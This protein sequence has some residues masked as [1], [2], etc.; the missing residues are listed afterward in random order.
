MG[1]RFWTNDWLLQLAVAGGYALLYLAIHPF[2]TAHWPIH[3][4]VRMACLLLIPYRFWPALLI[5]EALPNEYQVIPCLASLGP[6]WVAVRSV[7]PIAV[8]MLI[9]W[10]CRTWMP[11]FPSKKLIDIKALLVCGL[12]VSLG[13][14]VYSST[15]LAVATAPTI[16]FV[17]MNAVEYF[18]GPYLGIFSIV[19]W[20]LM[21]KLDYKPGHLHEQI[22][23]ALSSRLFLD[24]VALLIPALVLLEW[25]SYVGNDQVKQIA[26]VA[27]FLPMAWLTLKHGWRAAAV[28]GPLAI[29][30]IS[31]P[32]API[33]DIDPKTYA[34]QATLAVVVTCLFALG[35]RISVQLMDEE[36]E[37]RSALS[38]QRF[39]RQSLQLGEQRMRQTSQ[40]LEYLAGTLHITN[41]R[42]LE[43]MRRIVPNIESHAFYKQSVAMQSQVYRL[44]ESMHPV[45][46]R[47]R[48]LPA[49][50]NE[51]IARA[52]D[53]AGIAYRCEISG[54]GFTRL[55]PAVLT[56]TYRSACEAAV[57]VTSRLACNRV[58]L[59][60]RGGETRGKRW[61]MLRVE[62]VLEETG[63]ANAVYH[64]EE[65]K[66]LATKL[67]ASMLDI[68]EMRDH[69]RIFDGYLHLRMPSNRLRITVLLHDAVQEE[70]RPVSRLAPP[71]RLWVK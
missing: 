20:V 16:S 46:W 49:A 11:P 50:L 21:V 67:G 4:G 70:Q 47:E 26:P 13:G 5:G 23:R 59:V 54:R 71:L 38:V 29:A 19:P 8:A 48:G 43:Q 7:P 35:G 62:G 68:P 60:L 39:A 63:V 69:V 1:K 10:A 6:A 53:E 18:L 42:L 30:C 34:T 57:Y 58:N 44:A 55:A 51:T 27:M 3:A 65:R 64:S 15:A 14:M 12:L 24:T 37:K 2:S 56:A 52:L 31:L 36:K 40:A 17:P 9:V 33:N 45:A 25:V 66:R 22:R 61:V 32:I 28:S 41:G